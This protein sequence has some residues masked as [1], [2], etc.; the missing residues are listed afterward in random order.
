MASTPLINIF[1]T[2]P[3]NTNYLMK[4]IF[5]N[6]KN[7]E[8]SLVRNCD[9]DALYS[10]YYPQYQVISF[11]INAKSN[12]NILNIEKVANEILRIAKKF[13]QN[14]SVLYLWINKIYRA[15]HKK[16]SEYNSYI[17][18]VINPNFDKDPDIEEIQSISRAMNYLLKYL[19]DNFGDFR[20][21]FSHRLISLYFDV[22]SE[23]RL[24]RTAEDIK[25][26]MFH[27]GL[28]SYE[29]NYITKAH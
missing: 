21:T 27:A 18:I 22:S 12:A 24:C 29:V 7:D 26:L 1:S 10:F 16:Y 5:K 9:N 4:K 2:Q 13:D 23:D 3:V 15:S 17:Y 28:E 14:S 19:A 6:I 20:E 8:V 11:Y 25:H